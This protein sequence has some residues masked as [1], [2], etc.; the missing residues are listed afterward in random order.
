MKFTHTDAWILMGLPSNKISISLL[1]L[2]ERCDAL[3][4]TIPTKKEIEIALTKGIQAGIVAQDGRNLRLTDEFLPMYEEVYKSKGG[5]F[6][7]SENLLKKLNKLNI[8][9][10]TN[11]SVNLND[12]EFK[13]AIREYTN[14]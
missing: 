10:R 4:H 2:I 12:K 5:L 3:N 6:A 14:H 8:N 13:I 7:L 11:S 1:E 9:Q